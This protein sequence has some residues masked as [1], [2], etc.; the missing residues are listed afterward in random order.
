MTRTLWESSTP[1]RGVVATDTADRQQMQWRKA[2]LSVMVGFVTLALSVLLAVSA[3][4]QQPKYDVL[5]VEPAIDKNLDA[6]QREARAYSQARDVSGMPANRVA[7]VERYFR[8]Y[9]PAKI[10]QLDTTYQINEIMSHAV[11]SMRAAVRMQTPAASNLMRWLYAG[12]KP[13]AMGNYLPAARINAIHFIA[14]LDKSSQRGSI[15]QPYPFILKDLRQ[16]YDDANNPDGVRA[17]ALQG[18]ERFVR[19][20]P[21]NQIPAADRQSLTQEMTNLLQSDPPKGRD[22]LAHAF[23]QRYAVSILSNL[24]TDASLG[25]QFVSV[26]TKQTNPDLIALHSAA[27]VGV[28]PGKMAEGEV[29]TKDVLKQWAQRVL[30]AYRGEIERLEAME[31]TTRTSRFQPPPPESF[32]RETK[33]P[34]EK[35]TPRMMGG[36]MD[37]MMMEDSMMEDSM[38]DD[39]MMDDSMMM[40]DMMMGMDGMMGGMMPGMT[41]E[42]PQ[43]AEIV[44]SRKKL[45]CALQQV[46]LGVTGTATKVENVDSMQPKAGLIAA[47]PADSLDSVKS[48][49]QSVNDLTTNLNDKSIGT[50]REFIKMLSE[51]LESLESLASGK[52]ATVKMYEPPV[53][54]DFVAPPAGGGDEAAPAAPG[55]PGQP[56]PAPAADGGLEALMSQ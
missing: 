2:W 11:G 37:D 28:L 18:I 15:P 50:R 51:Q 38:M 45:N 39:M 46:L 24:S 12:L 32:V 22:D 4:G 20:T 8:Q 34:D 49:V 16:I 55:Q 26:S 36:M 30:A 52:K 5:P 14:H 29:Q 48:W 35:P 47:T 10:T 21:T 19:Y 9:V 13:V 40:D 43:P 1:R 54:D 23:L 25:K 3:S 17:A 27:A 41:L 44:A 33:D 56:A 31:N 6:V 7:V 42:K 53:F